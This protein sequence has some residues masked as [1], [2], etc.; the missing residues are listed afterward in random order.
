MPSAT[1]CTVIARRVTTIVARF[2]WAAVPSAPP[3]CGDTYSSASSCVMTPWLRRNTTSR[4][5]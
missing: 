5:W 2:G 3:F 1:A 4:A